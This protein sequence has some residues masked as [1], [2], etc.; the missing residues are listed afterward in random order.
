MT[1]TCGIYKGGKRL[2]TG[3]CTNGSTAI[4]SYTGTAPGTGRNVS[5]VVEDSGAHDGQ[6]HRTRIVLDAGADL[7]MSGEFPFPTA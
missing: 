6:T 2:G 3:E 4:G 1:T 7:T 5:V